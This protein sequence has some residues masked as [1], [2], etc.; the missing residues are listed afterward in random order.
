MFNLIEPAGWDASCKIGT[1]AR[2][3]FVENEN[4]ARFTNAEATDGYHTLWVKEN[5]A[6]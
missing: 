5:K 6:I 2:E 3:L 4:E 1:R